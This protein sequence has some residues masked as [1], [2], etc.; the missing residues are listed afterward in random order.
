[1]VRRM[2]GAL[3]GGLLLAAG[4]IATPAFADPPGDQPLPGYTI[5]NPPLE[6]LVVDGVPTQVLQGVYKNAAYDIEVPPQWNGELVMWAHGYRGNGTVLTVDPPE[7]GLRERFVQQGYAWAA[8]S[9][10][11]NGYDIRAGVLSTYDLARHFTELV[12]EPSRTYVTGVSMGGHVIGRSLEQYPSFYAGAL[13]MCGV[14]G[15][16]RLFDYYLDYNLIAQDLADVPAYP[17]PADYLT[18]AVPQIQV[19][20]GLAGLAP[21]GPDTLTERGKQLRAITI[22]RS[23]GPR[24]GADPSFAVWKDFLFFIALPSGIDTLA[25]DP[26]RIAQNLLTYYQ[27]NT[28]ER[29]NLTVQRVAPEDLRS[30]LSPFLTEIPRIG[31]RP[32]V[33]VMSLH[34]LGDLF[35]PFSMEQIYAKDVAR[36]G[37]SELLVQRAI[38]ASGHCEL[39]PTEVGT[40]WDELVGWVEARAT[41]P[42]AKAPE[43]D[44]V[45]DRAAVADAAFGCRFSD[46]AAYGTGSRPLYPPCPA[47]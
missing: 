24:P 14:L 23:G 43:G 41:D 21:V 27:P 1:M 12:D 25:G 29:V 9:Y 22:E 4:L 10:Y 35:V 11:A 16:Q 7:Y 32:R 6:P 40:A 5:E 37:Q 18:N 30:R 20:L 3:L 44:P 17:I 33:P 8:S 34:D 31:G 45:T 36:N 19:T 46:P 38:R 47:V 39:S 2:F 13:P 26:G 15:D 42:S 28:P